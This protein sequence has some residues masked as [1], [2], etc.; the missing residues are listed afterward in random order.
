MGTVSQ[1]IVESRRG[2]LS[3]DSGAETVEWRQWSGDCGVETVEWRQWG[4]DCGVET[5][6]WRHKTEILGGIP[7]NIGGSSSRMGSEECNCLLCRI[8]QEA[9]E[10]AEAAYTRKR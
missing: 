5:V 2:S 3:G 10:K 6:G 9:K 7:G 1:G 8:C 4:G